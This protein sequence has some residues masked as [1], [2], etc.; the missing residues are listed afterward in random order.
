MPAP[1]RH[2]PLTDH[3]DPEARHVRAWA[4]RLADPLGTGLVRDPGLLLR[5]LHDDREEHERDRRQRLDLEHRPHDGVH[6]VHD[7]DE[8]EVARR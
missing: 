3:V 2:H 6:R 8:L 5:A 7:R 1:A 4:H